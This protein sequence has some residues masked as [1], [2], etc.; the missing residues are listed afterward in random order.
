MQ[1]GRLGRCNTHIWVIISACLMSTPNGFAL[2]EQFIKIRLLLS[3]DNRFLPVKLTF[4]PKYAPHSASTAGW[5]FSGHL[6]LPLTCMT[7]SVADSWWQMCCFLPEI[8]L[9]WWD[10]LQCPGMKNYCMSWQ[11]GQIC[12]RH[13]ES[14][15]GCCP[16]G[17]HVTFVTMYQTQQ[18]KHISTS[19][20]S[21]KDS[22]S[23]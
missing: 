19:H 8:H 13:T 11:E 20:C 22:S 12:P 3:A 18:K 4:V 21:F 16:V 10:F 23:P 17:I 1:N 9:V 15:W 7:P 5:L 14:L 2:K 6:C